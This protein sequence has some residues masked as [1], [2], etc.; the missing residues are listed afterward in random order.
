[1][2]VA[3]RTTDGTRVVAASEPRTSGPWACPSCATRVAIKKG[4]IKVHHFAHFPP[5]QCE[6]G[7]GE[8]DAHSRCK[9]AIYETLRVLP[10]ASKWE[11]E[12]DLGSVRPDVSGYLGTQPL[13]IEVQSSSLTLDR[14]AHR[15]WEYAAKRVPILWLGLWHAG[16]AETRFSPAAWERWLHTLY[17]GRAYYWR[18]GATV[19]P[20]HF[21]DHQLWVE[22]RDWHDSEGD[23]QS[24]GGYHKTSRRWREAR[25]T[26]SVA[27]HEMAVSERAAWAGGDMSVPECSIWL[28]RSP[29]WW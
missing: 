4:Q 28:D 19:T 21:A 10:G 1:M 14:I 13:A 29:R 27:I 15:T 25:P 24:A 23:E 18:Y 6:Y 26:A 16:L 22:A 8:S 20:V 9:M 11:L 12:R 5:V 7:S 17:F 2:L 3:K